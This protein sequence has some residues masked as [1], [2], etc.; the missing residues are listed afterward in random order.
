MIWQT[1][2]QLQKNLAAAALVIFLLSACRS[3]PQP[4]AET[5][6]LPD[7]AR[8]FQVKQLTTVANYDRAQQSYD[9]ASLFFIAANRNGHV[10][11]QAYQY[12]FS[13][14]R[15]R[16]LTFQDGDADSIIPGFKANE[17]IYS[18]STDEIKE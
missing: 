12:F 4:A 3:G 17:I 14:Q 7:G 15:E 13:T 18:S 16:R 2:K 5:P 11:R 1:N 8:N 6:K 10:Q 9:G